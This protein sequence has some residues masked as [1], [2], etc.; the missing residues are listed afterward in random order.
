MK[1]LVVEDDKVS[2]TLLQKLLSLQGEAD[3]AEDGNAGIK[4]FRK[5]LDEKAPYDLVCLD[6]M[7][8]GMDG[9]GVL[10]MIRVM[11]KS[12]GIKEEDA[13]TIIMTTALADRKNV[14]DA[15]EHCNAYLIKPVHRE[16]LNAKLKELGLLEEFKISDQELFEEAPLEERDTE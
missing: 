16:K 12:Q 11:E 8:P 6:I 2:R 7:M 3:A 9:H 14:V 15:G 10:R 5:A 4:A 13:S 1:S